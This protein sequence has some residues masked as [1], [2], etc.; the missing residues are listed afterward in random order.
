MCDVKITC[1]ILCEAAHIIHVGIDLQLVVV[2]LSVLICGASARLEGAFFARTGLGGFM[3]SWLFLRLWWLICC[4]CIAFSLSTTSACYLKTLCLNLGQ[5][6]LIGDL[7]DPD[8]ML[9]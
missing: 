4:R 1:I 8:E 6:S 2:N 9:T 3:A 5:L 7:V